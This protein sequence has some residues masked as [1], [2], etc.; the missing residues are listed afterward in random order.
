MGAA[1]LAMPSIRV[2][3]LSAALILPCG[4]VAR[5]QDTPGPPP[6]H[7]SF[8]EGTA[9]VG[10]DGEWETAVIN[11]PLVEGDRVRTTA[12]RVQVLFPDGTAIDIDPYSEIVFVTASRV[13]VSAGSIERQEADEA[14]AGAAPVPY[15]P[16]ELQMYGDTFGQYGSWQNEAPYGAVW[17]PRVARTWR[18][19]YHGYWAPLP[20]YGWTWVGFDAWDWPTHHYGRWGYA[21]GSWFW[22]PGRVWAPAWVSWASAPGFVSWCPLGVNGS[23][24]FALS[25]GNGDPWT[26]W[27]IVRR[28]TFGGRGYAVHRYAVEP[29]HLT[30]ETPFIIQSR[31]PVALSVAASRPAPVV[32]PPRSFANG[33]GAGALA[34]PRDRTAQARVAA[35]PPPIRHAGPAGGRPRAVEG[36]PSPVSPR[37]DRAPV[38]ARASATPGAVPRY[39]P[40]PAA[41]RYAPPS[42]AARTDR[43]PVAPPADYRTPRAVPRYAPPAT[44]PRSDRMPAA[45]PAAYRTPQADRPPAPATHVE[46]PG[47]PS[48]PPPPP[49]SSSTPDRGV[50]APAAPVA[51]PRSAPAP[52]PAPARGRPAPQRQ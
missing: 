46:R 44:A 37:G 47:P 8:V 20:S 10:H 22:V 13:R 23:S 43:A 18:P 31:A 24:V 1:R 30:R 19:Y 51:A 2:V 16:Q 5:A 17:Y 42:A 34:V 29:H 52:A 3:L 7:I 35:S 39:A 32:A 27:T 41:P 9:L 49:S 38:E 28:D 50:R 36:L 21:R 33:A 12:G 6:A 11:L 48:P 14:A 40:P 4:L 26:G 15:L 25:I 45:P